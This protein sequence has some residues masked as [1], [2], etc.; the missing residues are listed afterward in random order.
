MGC[1]DELSFLNDVRGE[2]ITYKTLVWGYGIAA[3]SEEKNLYVKLNIFSLQYN[4]LCLAL[5][6]LWGSVT[7]D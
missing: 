2:H 1:Y 5:L 3:R 4:A 7:A 6:V